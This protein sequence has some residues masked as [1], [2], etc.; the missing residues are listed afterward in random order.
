[1]ERQDANTTYYDAIAKHYEG[2]KD[3]LAL[4]DTEYAALED[5]FV[6]EGLLEFVSLDDY[7]ASIKTKKTLSMSDVMACA[8]LSVQKDVKQ[9]QQ[10]KQTPKKSTA[11]LA[12]D[13]MVV[14]NSHSSQA[15]EE[16]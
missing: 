2:K 10:Q 14:R 16:V 15:G 12:Y 11:E 5:H 8:M 7:V 4:N 6:E 9:E 3:L 13:R 1:M